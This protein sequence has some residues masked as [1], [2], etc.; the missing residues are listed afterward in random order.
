MDSTP[1]G[2]FI[3]AIARFMALAG[4][5][6]L[7]AFMLVTV[8]NIVGRALLPLNEVFGARVFG[9]IP[10][11]YEIAEAG[12]AFATFAFLGWCTLT[13]GHAIVSL[14]TDKFPVRVNAMIELVMESLALIAAAFIAWRHWAGMVDKFSNGETSFI[15]RF[16]IWWAYAAG[17]IGAAVWVIVLIY[18]VARSARNAV[19]AIPEMPEAEIADE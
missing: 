2:R 9:P 13:R 4:G 17:M 7:V 16:P 5:A 11:D 1:V 3:Y 10:G 8:L 12:L 15:L 18:C 14:V 19:S 6:V